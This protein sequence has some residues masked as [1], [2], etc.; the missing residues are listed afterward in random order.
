MSLYFTRPGLWDTA[1][2]IMGWEE[3]AKGQPKFSL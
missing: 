2:Y 3:P 1:T